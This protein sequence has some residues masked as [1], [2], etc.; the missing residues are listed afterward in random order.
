MP[1]PTFVDLQGFIVNKKFIM[2]E[3]TVLKQGTVLTHYIFTSPMPRKFLTRFDRSCAFWL[4]A[5]Y[6]GLRWEDG[7]VPY[8]DAKHLITVAVFEDDAI[9]YV[10]GRKKQ[11]WM[12][13]LILDDEWEHMYIEILDAVYED[14]ESIILIWMTIILY[15]VDNMLRIARNKMD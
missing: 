10:K 13:N 9:V 3:V 7:M 6:Y 2:K 8:S 5:Y 12:W 14:M 11:T 15:D 1:V 4:S